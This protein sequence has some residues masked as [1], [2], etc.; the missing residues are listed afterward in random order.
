MTVPPRELSMAPP[1]P[2]LL[3]SWMVMPSM[4]TCTPDAMVSTGPSQILV[5]QPL[6]FP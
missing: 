4:S 1:C 3:A 6:V 5:W 2:A